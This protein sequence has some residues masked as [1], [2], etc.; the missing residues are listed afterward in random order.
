MNSSSFSCEAFVPIDQPQ[1]ISWNRQLNTNISAIQQ[2][3]TWVGTFYRYFQ[4]YRQGVCLIQSLACGDP[5]RIAITALKI[6]PQIVNETNNQ[7]LIEGTEILSRCTALLEEDSVATEWSVAKVKKA[8]AEFMTSRATTLITNHVSNVT[9]QQ[10]LIAATRI[11]AYECI[12]TVDQSYMRTNRGTKR[13]ADALK[14]TG[15]SAA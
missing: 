15:K 11:L 12:D 2:N 7:A 14:V 6:L 8:I 1:L 3:G 5:Y 9:V 4:N 13:S 10:E